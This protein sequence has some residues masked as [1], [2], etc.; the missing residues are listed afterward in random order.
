MPAVT[1]IF[2]TSAILAIFNADPG[3]EHAM[4]LLEGAAISTVNLAEIATAKSLDVPVLTTD[5][6][7]QRLDL[8]IDI[9]LIR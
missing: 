9:K 6:T 2:D 1:G 8:G 7:W 4:E 3:S 5:R